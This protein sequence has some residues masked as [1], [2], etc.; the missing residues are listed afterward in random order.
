MCR[1]PIKHCQFLCGT[2]ILFQNV[3][4]SSSVDE[5]DCNSLIGACEN[6]MSTLWKNCEHT[7]LKSSQKMLF[8]GTKLKINPD[9]DTKAV[10]GWQVRV[11]LIN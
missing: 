2:D 6:R 8:S 4:G 10:R 7:K 3:S 9:L 5:N 11:T 1:T